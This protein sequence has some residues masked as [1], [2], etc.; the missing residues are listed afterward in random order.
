MDDSED[1][2][3]AEESLHH[4]E[5]DRHDMLDFGPAESDH[6]KEDEKAEHGEVAHCHGGRRR[7]ADGESEASDASTSAMTP[8]LDVAHD[9]AAA[10]A[11]AAA[12]PAGRRAPDPVTVKAEAGSP[13]PP[14]E[15]GVGEACAS[16]RAGV[17]RSFCRAGAPVTSQYLVRHQITRRRLSLRLWSSVPSC[18][19][20][21]FG[22]LIVFLSGRACIVYSPVFLYPSIVDPSSFYIQ[23]CSSSNYSLFPYLL[24]IHTFF[25]S[26]LPRTHTR[27]HANKHRQLVGGLR[28]Q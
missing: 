4:H 16:A 6:F 15:R 2:L 25:S 20:W 13:Q 24:V 1:C 17:F 5:D 21:L 27:T 8:P 18:P 28:R 11:A 12:G 14:A 7:A 10:A 9:A 3:H 19:P 26:S 23:L 22:R